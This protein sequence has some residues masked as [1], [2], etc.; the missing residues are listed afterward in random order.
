VKVTLSTAKFQPAL[1]P[2][3]EAAML[4]VLMSVPDR[5]NVAAPP[6]PATGSR[7][8]GRSF[9]ELFC[10]NANHRP[11]TLWNGFADV[12]KPYAREDLSICPLYPRTPVELFR[13]R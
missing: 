12:G 5:A 2:G 9:G 8:E 13:K 1:S 6:A 4:T 10:A 7:R 3:V 11:L